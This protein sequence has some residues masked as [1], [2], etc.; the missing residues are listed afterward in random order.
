MIPPNDALG[1]CCVALQQAPITPTLQQLTYRVARTV[2]EQ[3]ARSTPYQEA[4][5]FYQLNYQ[6]VRDLHQALVGF[7]WVEPERDAVGPTSTPMR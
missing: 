7:G 4:G 1:L 5:S 6:H 3:M 2:Y